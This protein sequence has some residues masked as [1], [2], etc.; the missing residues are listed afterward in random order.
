MWTRSEGKLPAWSSN[1]L[2]HGPRLRWIIPFSNRPANAHR[3]L[4]SFLWLPCDRGSR[5]K[6][7]WVRRIASFRGLKT[8]CCAMPFSTPVFVGLWA[9]T[10]RKMFWTVSSKDH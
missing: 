9:S 5:R 6:T 4:S 1:S 8:A 3:I 10:A 7:R 2:F